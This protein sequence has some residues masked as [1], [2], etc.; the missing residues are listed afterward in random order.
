MLEVVTALNAKPLPEKF[1][2]DCTSASVEGREANVSV[3]LE[4][5]VALNAEE[6]L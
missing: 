2:G 6:L 3:K 5:S 4:S 1:V